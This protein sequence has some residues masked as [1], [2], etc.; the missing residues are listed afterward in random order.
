M[1]VGEGLDGEVGLHADPHTPAYMR[2]KFNTPSGSKLCL[3]PR[4]SLKPKADGGSNTS[5]AARNSSGARISVVW[6]WADV[7]ARRSAAAAGSLAAVATQTR[8][9]PQS[10]P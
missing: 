3:S 10:K 7:T 8:P 4:L 1:R 5:T 6:P 9:P 2:P